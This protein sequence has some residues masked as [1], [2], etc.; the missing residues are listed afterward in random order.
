[1]SKSQSE[2]TA[3]PLRGAEE[4]TWST[5]YGFGDPKEKGGQ[6]LVN[7]P[8][9]FTK[10]FFDIYELGL[11]WEEKASCFMALHEYLTPEAIRG[12][13]LRNRIILAKYYPEIS[14]WA[15]EDDEKLAGV[16]RIKSPENFSEIL[17]WMAEECGCSPKVAQQAFARLAEHIPHCFQGAPYLAWV[18]RENMSEFFP[19]IDNNYWLNELLTADNLANP[20]IV[21]HCIKDTF[22]R[23]S[24][25][26]GA[27]LAEVEALQAFLDF[28]STKNLKD[29]VVATASNLLN[30]RFEA[31]LE[32]FRNITKQPLS[33]P[34]LSTTGSAVHD[35]AVN[36]ASLELCETQDKSEARAQS[37]ADAIRTVL[38]E[39]IKQY[40]EDQISRGKNH[41]IFGSVVYAR[42]DIARARWYFREYPSILQE[43]D[44]VG[45][46]LESYYSELWSSRGQDIANGLAISLPNW[47]PAS[48]LEPIIPSD[49]PDYLQKRYAR[50]I[51]DPNY[52]ESVRGRRIENWDANEI[53]T[54]NELREALM[55]VRRSIALQ[56]GD[57]DPVRFLTT[58][59][60]EKFPNANARRANFLTGV[61]S[62]IQ[63]GFIVFDEEHGVLQLGKDAETGLNEM[64]I[65]FSSDGSSRVRHW[66]E[67]SPPA[68][69]SWYSG[70]LM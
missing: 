16:N 41:L 53:E 1:M 35:L 22:H 42:Q 23:Y 29:Q 63:S 34:V 54:N 25:M 33:Y 36:L 65:I 50:M 5:P 28:A 57:V 12:L 45:T 9:E 18:E 10:V 52:A 59:L 8:G 11:T 27:L 21:K 24:H 13:S 43:L 3:S 19:D 30:P 60:Q 20:E 47:R 56:V 2:H 68:L 32:R 31:S 6:D 67:G 40:T 51:F 7:N 38:L 55:L 64:D 61:S 48:E 46:Q 58:K 66:K 70:S 14:E 49:L 17:W 39:R 26:D 15:G 4:S 37:I 44:S 62:A 69:Y